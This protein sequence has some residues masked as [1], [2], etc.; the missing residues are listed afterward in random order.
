MVKFKSEALSSIGPLGKRLLF[1]SSL[2]ILKFQDQLE[3]Y[4]YLERT[5]GDISNAL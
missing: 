5:L 2:G 4:S 1:S 3:N